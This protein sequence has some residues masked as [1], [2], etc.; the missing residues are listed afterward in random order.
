[1]PRDQITQFSS[2][3]EKLHLS[4]CDLARRAGDE[5]VYL[6][7]G[8]Q[9]GMLWPR[10]V[11]TLLIRSAAVVEQT[12]HGMTVRLW[13][14][15]FEWTLPERLPAVA[16]LIAYFE[17]VESARQRGFKFLRSD[18]DLN[19]SIPAPVE[20]KTLEHLLTDALNLSKKH[21]TDAET[22]FLSIK[23]LA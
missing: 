13:D 8:D 23:A 2:G 17:E 4:R 16:D 14:D 18:D 22:V 19:K 3:F 1:M 20:L 21:F 5:G 12:I 7:A 15:P 10:S 9:A 6:A 11:G